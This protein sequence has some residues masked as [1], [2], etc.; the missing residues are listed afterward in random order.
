MTKRR[1]LSP[2]EL[3]EIVSLRELGHSYE[4]IG[5]KIGCS[6]ETV[7]WHCCRLGVEPPKTTGKSWDSIKGPAVSKRGDHFV[8][9]FTPEEDQLLLEMRSS[10]AKICEIARKLGRGGNSVTG[11][12]H[13]LARREARRERAA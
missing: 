8:R 11:R 5:R 9:R 2:D 1:R 4:W 13:A 3:D 10:G 12:L 7:S 6:S